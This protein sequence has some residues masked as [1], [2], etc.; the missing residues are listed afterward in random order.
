[1]KNE[2]SG[3]KTNRTLTIVGIALCVVLVP[4][5]VINCILI[6]KSFVNKDEIPNIGGTM[7]LIVL[8][9]SMYPDIKSGD[10]I[11]CKAIDAEDVEEE[12]VISFY[13]PASKNK[14]VV[15]HEV[16]EIIRDGDKLFFRTQGTNNNTPDK[17]LVPADNVIAEYTGIRFPAIGSIAIFMQSTA[18]L[19]ICI[20]VPIV[21]F[22]GYDLIR[23]KKY[24]KE[25]GEDIAALRAELEALRSAQNSTAASQE[26]NADTP[27][28]KQ[29]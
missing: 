13:D 11:I 1:M 18:G 22:V 23:R 21:L 16:I 29:E 7:P 17:L 27:S 25:K 20:V 26:Q 2:K 9:D 28:E 19:I 15:T 8:S 6:V 5:L 4:I 24:D 3:S 12:D 10:L 14:A